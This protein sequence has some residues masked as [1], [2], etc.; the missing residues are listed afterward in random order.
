MLFDLITFAPAPQ[1]YIPHCPR[2]AGVGVAL[3]CYYVIA[4]ARRT[5]TTRGCG[6]VVEWTQRRV[7]ERTNKQTYTRIELRGI[8]WIWNGGGKRIQKVFN[9]NTYHLENDTIIFCC[10]K[11]YVI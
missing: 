7:D 11:Y 5:D 8:R 9:E 2:V 4:D 1:H 6:S 3:R 10:T